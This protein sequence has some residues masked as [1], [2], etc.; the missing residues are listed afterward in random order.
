MIVTHV[1]PG[2]VLTSM[3]V[4]NFRG[5]AWESTSEV[6]LISVRIEYNHLKL[7]NF[8]EDRIKPSEVILFP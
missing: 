8:C 5:C 4:F 1:T 3:G 2:I 7:F 6:R